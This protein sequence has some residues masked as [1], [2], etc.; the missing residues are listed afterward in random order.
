MSAEF[1][2]EKNALRQIARA[3]EAIRRKHRLLKYGKENTARTLDETF[4]PLEK[5]INITESSSNE[6][7]DEIKRMKLELDRDEP[8]DDDD[9]SISSTGS[10]DDTYKV[11]NENDATQIYKEAETSFETAEEDEEVDHSKIKEDRQNKFI[12]DS[13]YS[14]HLDKIYGVRKEKGAYMIGNSPILFDDLHVKAGYYNGYPRTKSQDEIR[15]WI[16]STGMIRT[17]SWI[18]FAY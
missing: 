1:Q 10:F 4:K 8:I 13:R 15:E 7:K 6:I 3:R 14:K 18:D 11:D 5:L 9:K 2:R 16:T 12:L 17:N